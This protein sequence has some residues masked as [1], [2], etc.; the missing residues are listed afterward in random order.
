MKYAIAIMAV[1]MV[2]AEAPKRVQVF[3]S[4][5]DIDAFV[6][7]ELWGTK[8]AARGEKFSADKLNA[9]L[10][11]NVKGSTLTVGP[12]EFNGG[13][14]KIKHL[15][16]IVE[17]TTINGAEIPE[18]IALEEDAGKFVVSFKTD[19]LHGLIMFPACEKDALAKMHKGDWFVASGSIRVIFWYERTSA[20]HGVQPRYLFLLEADELK[21]TKKPAK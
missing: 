17:R 11:K 6:P 18:S 8:N 21:R 9:W 2:A 5:A 7:K 4:K 19:E 1:M 14:W 16:R 15:E 13:V 12:Q 20:V 10:R 3:E